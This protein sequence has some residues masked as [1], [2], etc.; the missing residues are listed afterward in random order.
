MYQRQGFKRYLEGE[1]ERER[2]SKDAKP[3]RI[4]RLGRYEI[5]RQ[6]YFFKKLIKIFATPKLTGQL[7]KNH[8]SEKAIH[9]R[10]FQ[11]NFRFIWQDK[12]EQTILSG[13]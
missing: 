3:I 7:S 2:E 1:S 10:N 5:D 6:Q 8:F 13:L 11:S 4:H 12:E 9:R